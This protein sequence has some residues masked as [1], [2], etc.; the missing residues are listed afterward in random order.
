[1]SIF[2]SK[3][4]PIFV[5][6]V[7]LVVLFLILALI[8]RKKRRFGMIFLIVALVILW[9]GGNRWVAMS[10]THSLEQRY[11]G[12]DSIPHAPAIVVLGGGT[13]PEENPRTS[14]EINGAGDRVV[15][16]WRLYKEGAADHLLLS[17]GDISFQDTS[18]S[19][20]ATE[21]E[22]FLLE[23][24]VPREV[25]WLDPDSANT[26][27]NA[28]NSKQILEE[29]NIHKLILITSAMHMPRAMM[30]FQEGGWEI[31]PAP[32]D[33]AVTDAAWQTLWHGDFLQVLINF[34]PSASNLSM[35][36]N[37]LK[38]YYGLA[39]YSLFGR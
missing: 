32:T 14:V 16:T 34:F 5:Y 33:T 4:L 11:P 30:M 17:G 28:V 1:M 15:Y 18:G 9:V 7:G 3:F 2:L 6:P 10:L 36:T 8:L 39:F 35:T 22:E 12:L 24:G 23:L 13:E 37:A 31:I 19:S 26:Y 20:P 21:M 38:E 29:H 25:M 27:E